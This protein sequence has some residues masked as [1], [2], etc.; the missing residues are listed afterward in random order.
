MVKYTQHS[1]K[2]RGQYGKVYTALLQN[3]ET[4]PDCP[5]RLLKLSEKKCKNSVVTCIIQY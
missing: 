1:Y 3:E 4:E 2:I 5:H